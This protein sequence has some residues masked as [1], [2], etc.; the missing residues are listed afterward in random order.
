MTRAS[1]TAK[2]FALAFLALASVSGVALFLVAHDFGRDPSAVTIK[3]G[4]LLPRNADLMANATKMQNGLELA[5]EDLLERHKGTLSIEFHHANGCFERETVPAVRQFVADGIPIIGASFCLFGHIPI[6]PLTEDNKIITFNTAAN[7]DAVLDKRF[8]FSTNVEIKDDAARMAAFAYEVMGHRRAMVM[9]LDSP[10]GHDYNKYFSREFSRLGGTVLFSAAKAPDARQFEDAIARIKTSEPDLIVTAHF[11]VPLGRFFRQL[12]D[13]NIHA[14][15]LGN[16]ETEDSDVLDAP[17][18]A[19]EG[20]VFLSSEPEIATETMI[21]FQRR[22]I[23]K[24]GVAPDALV[25][26]CYDDLLLSVEAYLTCSGD[27]ECM[28]DTLHRVSGYQGVSGVTE[29]NASGATR[30]VTAFKVIKHRTFIR[31]QPRTTP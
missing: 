18:D 13:A 25:A 5:K 27:R 6:L 11:G 26:H 2:R 3:V 9:H 10:F 15:I 1:W 8:A 31:H 17:G 20:V 4:T 7:P 16:Y 14:A 22:Y 28:R 24:Y 30:R 19:S 23:R 21:R 12:R 29:I